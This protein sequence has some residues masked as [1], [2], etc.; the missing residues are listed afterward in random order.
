M[1]KGPESSIGYHTTLESLGIPQD[2][3]DKGVRNWQDYDEYLKEQAARPEETIIEEAKK[4]LELG[5]TPGPKFSNRGGSDES[6]FLSRGEAR[7]AD[8][9]GV[10]TREEYLNILADKDYDKL[11]NFERHTLEQAAR[12][13]ETIIEEAKKPLGLGYTPGLEDYNIDDESLTMDQID[14]FRQ[15]AFA[16]GGEDD[17]EFIKYNKM[18]VGNRSNTL[19]NILDDK[20]KKPLE[21][22]DTPLDDD[23]DLSDIPQEF[24]DKAAKYYE[25]NPAA[26]T[27]EGLEAS[28]I[29]Q[30][31]VMQRH[32]ENV[33]RY[34]QAEAEKAKEA[35]NITNVTKPET[36]EKKTWFSRFKKSKFGKAVI[37]GAATFITLGIGKIIYDNVP[38][39]DNNNDRIEEAQKTPSSDTEKDEQEKNPLIG[40]ELDNNEAEGVKFENLYYSTMDKKQYSQ[41][42]VGNI[43]GGI[44]NDAESFKNNIAEVHTNIGKGGVEAS[45]A[46][47]LGYDMS[48][49]SANE[50]GDQMENN[51]ELREKVYNFIKDKYSRM[52]NVKKVILQGAY[53]TEGALEDGKGGLDVYQS[54]L[55]KTGYAA[56]TFTIDGKEYTVFEFCAQFGDKTPIENVTEMPAGTF[57]YAVIDTTDRV[58]IDL[59]GE[60]GSII[61]ETP[62]NETTVREE[63]GG[64]AVEEKK[65][66]ELE[67]VEENEDPEEGNGEETPKEETPEIPEET[68]DGKNYN[69]SPEGWN[70]NQ[71]VMGAGDLTKSDTEAI[72]DKETINGTEAPGSAIEANQDVVAPGAERV[73]AEEREEANIPT[74]ETGA[75]GEVG[76]NYTTEWQGQQEA[77]AEQQVVQDEAN[78]N[79]ITTGGSTIE[80]ENGT[81]KTR[82]EILASQGL[83]PDGTPIEK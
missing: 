41:D 65:E 50:L 45:I 67:V 48:G 7:R 17:S 29:M 5:D 14:K 79:E 83:N 38:Q 12:P 78:A 30:A 61:L 2:A 54:Q 35:N 4:P 52:E 68:D 18:F 31:K 42:L 1:N 20:A 73:L 60:G 46:E 53:Y 13:E 59:P 82:E 44:F 76:L 81:V 72:G 43:D 9:Y 26:V 49:L 57:T 22:G 55:D 19:K 47:H 32:A 8:Q 16:R 74:T 58:V 27:G 56:Y 40:E 71:E 23:K 63:T 69:K 36:K 11:S 37:A 28:I 25:E 34:K 6:T 51:L 39:S 3:L 64:G 10:S 24:L 21:L 33:E 15:D 77:Q 75:N 62:S 70:D 80:L 66:E